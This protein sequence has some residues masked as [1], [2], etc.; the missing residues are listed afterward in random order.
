MHKWIIPGMLVAVVTANLYGGTISKELESRL[1]AASPNE[2]IKVLVW[3]SEQPDLSALKNASYSTKSQYLRDFAQRTQRELLGFLNTKGATVSDVRSFWLVNMVYLEATP[4]VIREIANRQDVALVD[5]SRVRHIVEP[6]VRR[7]AVKGDKTVEWNIDKIKADSVWAE[8]GL[9]GDGVIVGTMDTGIDPTHP[10][11][12]GNFSGHFF[13][14]VNHHTDPYDDH[15]HGTHVAGTIAGGD[16]PGPFDHDI[17]IAYNAQIVSAKAFNAGGSGSDPDIIACFQYFVTL[18]AD[19]GVDIKA[20]SN[21]WGSTDGTDTTFLPY[22]RAWHEFDIIPVFANGNSGPSSGSASTPGNFPNVIGVGAT[23]SQDNIA[24]FS[25]RGPAPNQYPWSDTT[26]WSR[27]DW[28]FIKPD[29]SAPGAG[30]TSSVPGGGYETWDGT[31]MA[32]PHITGVIALMFEMNPSLDYSTVYDILTNYGVDHPQ[33][34]APYP[35]NDYGWGRV[36][37]LLAVENTPSLDRPFLRVLSPLVDDASGNGNGIPDPGET[38]TM[39]VPLRNIGLGLY[40]V[41]ATLTSDDPDIT[42]SDNQSNYGDILMDST[43]QGD[44][45][46]FSTDENRRPG[47]NTSFVITISGTDS[48]GAAYTKVDTFYV[49]IGEPTFYPWFT[50][51]FES[52]L[53]Q[54]VT[55][56]TGNWALTDGD[57]HSPAHSATDSPNGEYG[58]NEHKY[59]MTASPIDLSNAYFARI[60]LW[61]KYSLESGYDYGYIQVSTDSSDAAEWTT[62]DRVNGTQDEWQEK[63]Y[64]ISAFAGQQ[65]YIRFLLETDASSMRDGWYIDDVSVEQDVSLEGVVL[66]LRGIDVLD[67]GGNG[68]I[69]PGENGQIVVHFFNMGTDTGRNL[70]FTLRTDDQYVTIAD[71]QFAVAEFPPQQEVIDTFEISAD[72]STPREHSVNFVIDVVGDNYSADKEFG[73]AIGQK[74]VADPTGPDNYGYYAYEDIDSSY[75]SHPVFEWVE[76]APSAGGPGTALNLGDD[77]GETVTLPFTFN[78]YG[79]AYN[80]ITICSN[81]WAAMGLVSDHDFNNSGIPSNDGP[82]AMLAPLWDDLDPRNGGEIAYYADNANHRF[83]IE[84]KDVPHYSHTEDVE[85]FQIILYDPAYYP[86]PTGDGEIVFQ[87][88]TD[89]AQDDFTTGIEDP[90]ETIGIQYYYDGDMDRL[91][92][93]VAAGRAIKFTTA[94]PS[95]IAEPVQPP[96]PIR[97][98]MFHIAPTLVSKQAVLTLALPTRQ[99]VEVK[100][101]DLSGREIQTVFSGVKGAGLHRF[102]WKPTE[103]PNGVYFVALSAGDTRI[104]RK[105]VILK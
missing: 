49:K 38:V 40:N 51:D 77:D 56:G 1:K 20:V 42:I 16:G 21:S 52:G 73:L 90:T 31:S 55:G 43:V 32:T 2:H 5:I 57:S 10:A 24:D 87:Y 74:T 98:V 37:A 91:A 19:S 7:A 66:S 68:V 82:P 28:N 34:G 36:N 25:S 63:F 93:G 71:S 17:G 96:T 53:G 4:E 86:T 70:T 58:N 50:D 67:D 39:Y 97:Q 100:V 94:L 104:V 6:V 99:S 48:S 18:K 23:N 72:P 29:I 78:Y 15:G 9:S 54:W 26:L 83:I 35:N 64:D 14:A 69:D 33:Q 46:V 47:L 41:T 102:T 105:A 12:Q 89:P 11:L 8:Y 88:L 13:D 60:H 65:V 30:V 101:Y 76:I 61:Q 45:F 103:L 22:V 81:G 79:A 27:P 92:V 59:L 84:W 75:S 3:M 44:G 62:I 85:N 80:Q 95:G